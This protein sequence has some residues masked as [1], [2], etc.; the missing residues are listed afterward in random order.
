M[1]TTPAGVRVYQNYGGGN[2]QIWPEVWAT[3]SSPRT[4]RIAD[5]DGDGKMDVVVAN[6]GSNAVSAFPGDGDCTFGTRTDYTVGSNPWD[7]AAADID[8]DGDL[9]L[10]VACVGSSQ[11]SVLI[12]Q[13][14][15]AAVDGPARPAQVELLAPRPNPSRA[16]T[17]IAFLLPREETV[18]LAVL[19]LQGRTVRRLAENAR[20]AAGRSA[21]PWDERDDAGQAAAPGIY[22]VHLTL[23][24]GS[25]LAK[26]L[27]LLH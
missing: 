10:M 24:D 8:R 7:I 3:G 23:A 18:T 12:N 2:L 22:F 21:V 6:F 5:F 15:A 20:F 16:G 27:E 11:I 14:Y 1:V 4:F 25:V 19:D 26:K 9:D 13:K 17:E